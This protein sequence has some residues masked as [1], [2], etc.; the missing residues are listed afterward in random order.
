MAVPKITHWFRMNDMNVLPPPTAFPVN[1]SNRET[2]ETPLHFCLDVDGVMTTGEFY[3]SADGKMMKVFG[4]D[5]HDALLLLQPHI[6]IRFVTGDRKG[7]QIS[8]RR[9]VEDMK[10]SI[11][12]VSTFDR[13]NWIDENLSLSRTIYIGDGIFDGGL[14]DRVYYAIA[15]ADAFPKTRAKAN[16]VTSCRGG[17]RAVAEAALHILERFFPETGAELLNLT[18]GQGEWGG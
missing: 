7:Y 2:R 9:I 11:D 4:P 17:R 6:G 5:D 12:L 3:Y 8:R 10:M 14:F 18:S 15:P 16:Y 13:A 1:G